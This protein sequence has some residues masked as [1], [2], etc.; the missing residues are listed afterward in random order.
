MVSPANKKWFHLPIKSGF[1]CVWII[2]AVFVDMSV[3]SILALLMP[4]ELMSLQTD[5]K[6]MPQ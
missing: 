4:H 2:C 5:E 3:E 6:K 1:T